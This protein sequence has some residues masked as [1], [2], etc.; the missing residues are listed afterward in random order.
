MLWTKESSRDEDDQRSQV[1]EDQQGVVGDDPQLCFLRLK[2]RKCSRLA[3]SLERSGGSGVST[4]LPA[5]SS[6]FS[7]S[8]WFFCSFPSIPCF[9]LVV[10]EWWKVARS[11]RAA[12]R[13]SGAAARWNGHRSPLL[14]PSLEPPFSCLI[15]SSGR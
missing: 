10:V 1:G 6:P 4:N 12:G 15:R 5:P 8:I 13:R 9:D 3:S 7:P 11:W 2:M 14:L